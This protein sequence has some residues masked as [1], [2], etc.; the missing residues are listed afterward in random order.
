[1]FISLFSFFFFLTRSW[2]T[3]DANDFNPFYCLLYTP[4]P[5]Y[6][7]ISNHMHICTSYVTNNKYISKT[8]IGT[9]S[10][11][12]KFSQK[13]GF[14]AKISK[15]KYFLSKGFWRK[16]NGIFR[17]TSL[18]CS[19]YGLITSG[20]DFRQENWPTG[21]FCDVFSAF[22]RLPQANKLTPAIRRLISFRRRI[23]HSYL[24]GGL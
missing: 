19:E 9:V 8:T 18:P 13:F 17:N 10:R 2:E 14:L 3:L 21:N 6:S 1:M 7:T 24:N 22:P 20:T 12:G 16:Q 23:F 4:I 5:S 11:S 15:T